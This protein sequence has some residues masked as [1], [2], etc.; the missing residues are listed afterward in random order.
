MGV[1]IDDLFFK[2]AGS[3]SFVAQL[4]AGESLI[5]NGHAHIKCWH[6]GCAMLVP[7]WCLVKWRYNGED[8]DDNPGTC[9][10]KQKAAMRASIF[11]S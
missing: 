5:Q 11:L 1:A 9:T 10:W 8:G 2:G 6:A 7:G 4:L 3:F